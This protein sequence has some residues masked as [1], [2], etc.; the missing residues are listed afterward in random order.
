MILNAQTIYDYNES[1]KCVNKGIVC[2]APVTNLNF[3]QTGDVRACC[4]NYKHILGKWPAQSIREIWQ[5]ERIE[6][7]RNFIAQ[8]NLGGGCIECGKMIES[9]NHQGVRAKYYDEFAQTLLRKKISG[10]KNSLTG[11]FTYPKVM[12]FELSN[13]C[14]LECVMCNGSF[15]SSIRK[16]REKLPPVVSPYNEKFVDE[17]EE[18]IPHLT[19]AK[20]L[21]GEPFMIE[22]YLSIWERILRINPDIRIHITT[23]GTFL[24]KRIKNLLSGLRAGIIVSIDS[25]IKETYEKIRMNGNY[26][27]VM[28]NLHY[29]IDYAKQKNTF[30]SIAACPITHNWRELPQM[31]EFC[32]DKNIALYFNVVFTPFELSLRELPV[33]EL[34]KVILFLQSY[35]LPVIIGN[36]QSPRNLSIKAYADFIHLLSGW[37]DEH[38]LQQQN[39][40]GSVVY[41]EFKEVPPAAD[42]DLLLKEIS[43][44]IQRQLELE[45]GGFTEEQRVLQNRFSELLLST[46]KDEAFESLNCIV[47]TVN[48]YQSIVTSEKTLNKL[49]RIA[50]LIESHPKRS[51]VLRTM[52]QGSPT[53]LT[54]FLNEMELEQLEQY[55]N[56]Q[57]NSLV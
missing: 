32:M 39:H 34:Q 36:P 37:L 26:E 41:D 3:E 14:N 51:N 4:Y 47:K 40:I 33:A 29:F 52:A 27:K 55:F 46:P 20:F 44:I 21:G 24:N 9:G 35:P 48:D 28:E 7:L 56:A 50:T 19:D 10:I 49:Q 38:R 25:V 1:R 16:N 2:H 6:A 17:L 31:L 15:S 57:F 12:E 18:F 11:S 23:N 22:I 13:Q 5:G 45:S 53:I 43:T 54:S 8:N 42:I 30:I